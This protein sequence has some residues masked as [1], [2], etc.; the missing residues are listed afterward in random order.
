MKCF[1][2]HFIGKCSK[3][4]INIKKPVHSFNSIYTKSN[5]SSYYIIILFIK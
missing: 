1:D 4:Q 5:G 3:Q 2:L